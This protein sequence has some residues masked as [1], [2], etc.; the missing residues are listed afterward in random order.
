MAILNL[1]YKS[2]YSFES[3]NRVKQPGIMASEITMTVNFEDIVNTT[4]QYLIRS[5][6]DV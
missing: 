4:H 5:S 2:S 6:D 1:H 3:P